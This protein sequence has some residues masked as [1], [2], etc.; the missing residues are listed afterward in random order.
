MADLVVLGEDG[1]WQRLPPEAVLAAKEAGLDDAPYVFAIRGLSPDTV[2][3]VL[4]HEHGLVRQD[5]GKQPQVFRWDAVMRTRESVVDH[6]RT[7]SGVRRYSQTRFSFTLTR[8][9]GAKV[10]IA[11]SDHREASASAPFGGPASATV[12]NHRYFEF[13]KSACAGVARAQLPGA[14]AT[15]ERGDEVAFGPVRLTRDGLRRRL[16]RPVAW[17]GLTVEV[18]GGWITL[19]DREGRT[20]FKESVADVPNSTLFRTLLTRLARPDA[21][22]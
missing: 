22:G 4:A 18:D 15:L 11:G 12:Q 7:E 10:K 1:P 16:R 9:D 3:R 5:H 19:R 14:L 20:A 8:E 17:D 13:G 2:H 6:Y 21:Q